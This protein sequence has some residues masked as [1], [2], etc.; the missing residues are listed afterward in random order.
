MKLVSANVVAFGKLRGVNVSFDRGLNVFR[1][2]NAYGKTTLCNFIRAMLYGFKYNRVGGVTDASHF[3]PWGGNERFGGSLTVE[4]NGEIFRIERFFGTTQKQETLRV[5]NEKTGRE[6][7]WQSKRK[8]ECMST[9]ADS[10]WR[11]IWSPRPRG[12]CSC[13]APKAGLTFW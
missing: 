1:Q 11:C 9:F 8:P 3:Q 13:C 5:F 12:R 4:H 2:I 6:V 7:N 10:L